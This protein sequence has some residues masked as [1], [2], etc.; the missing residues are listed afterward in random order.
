MNDT[1][2]S[3]QIWENLLSYRE[4]ISSIMSQANPNA[5][6]NL[7]SSGYYT[8][9]DS[10]QQDVII[11][12]FICAYFGE[13]PNINNINPLSRRIPVPNWRITFDGI[14]KIKAL[15]KY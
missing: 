11:G 1:T 14:G 5:S 8:G 3:N 7:E 2:L 12:S 9:Y 10:T 4:S 6:N 13:T 15:R